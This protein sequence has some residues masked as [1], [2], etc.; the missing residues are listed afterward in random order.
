MLLGTLAFALDL[1]MVGGFPQIAVALVHS[2][3]ASQAT[4]VRLNCSKRPVKA[5]AKG[6]QSTQM[7]ALGP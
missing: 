4:F 1:I 2:F 7:E 5:P 6:A 3:V